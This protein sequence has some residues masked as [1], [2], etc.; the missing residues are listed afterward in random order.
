MIIII[1]LSGNPDEKSG[2]TYD[3]LRRHDVLQTSNLKK[4]PVESSMDSMSESGLTSISFASDWSSCSNKSFDKY[5]FT[6]QFYKLTLFSCNNLNY[7]FYILASCVGSNHQILCIRRC[8]LFLLVLQKLLRQTMG[9][10]H[11]TSTSERW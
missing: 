4:S 7:Q 8:W 11:Q 9:L 1:F 3:A 6:S 10:S 5:A 2:L